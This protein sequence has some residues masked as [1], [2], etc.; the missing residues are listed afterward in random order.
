MASTITV[1]DLIDYARTHVKLAP[2]QGLG[3]FADQPALRWANKIKK[4]IIQSPYDWEWNK[5]SIPSFLTVNNK[6]EYNV[7]VPDIGWLTDAY[8]ELEAS[9]ANNR[10]IR[11]LEVRR[12]IRKPWQKLDPSQI[13]YTLDRNRNPVLRLD[14][15]PGSTIWRIFVDYQRRP[16]R[17]TTVTG[18]TG[19]FDPIPDEMEDILSQFFIA[20]AY[21]LVDR[22]D[23]L[24]ELALAEQM[25]QEH[26][27]YLSQEQTEVGFVPYR[28]LMLG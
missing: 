18:A 21:K 24:R 23:H 14:M 27:A 9:A 11:Y 12:N 25:L 17:I 1:Q 26:R 10:D 4:H 3:G 6:A 22:Q 16:S 2:L 19:T 7:K 28:S 8:M 13:C 5:A 20:L 15:I